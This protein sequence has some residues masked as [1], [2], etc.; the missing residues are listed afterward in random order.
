MEEAKNLE[1]ADLV[2][3]QD[4]K[5]RAMA[6]THRGRRDQAMEVE[7]GHGLKVGLRHDPKDDLLDDPVLTMEAKEDRHRVVGRCL[8]QQ[9]FST[10]Y[11][12]LTWQLRHHR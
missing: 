1:E 6:V 11:L 2:L 4:L 10:C 3:D 7:G 12:L 5:G 9:V 8:D